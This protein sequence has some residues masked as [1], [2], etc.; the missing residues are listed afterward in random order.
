M[1]VLVTGAN[2]FLAANIVRELNRRGVPVRGLV[3]PSADLSA[4]EGADCELITGSYLNERDL[5]QAMETCDFVIHPAAFTG[6]TPTDLKYYLEPNVEGTRNVVRVCLQKGIKRLVYVSTVNTIGFG[7]ENHPGREDWPLNGRP[8]SHSGYAQS[9]VLAENLIREAIDNQG[10][11][12]VIVNPTFIIGP[13]DAKPSSNRMLLIYFERSFSLIPPGGKNFVYVG[14][15][16]VA[17]C[18]ALEMGKS[19]ERYI[20][21]HR[22]LTLNAFF[23]LVEKVVGRK[24][25]RI[26]IPGPLIRLAGQAGQLFDIFGPDYQLDPV[27]A[28]ILCIR[29]FYTAEKA[30]RELN[31]PQTPIERAI[32]E[33]WE[34]L[35]Q[36]KTKAG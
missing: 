7:T 18:N 35:Q 16:A 31:M 20:L 15:V 13:Y 29:N 22:N 34:W 6:P 8:F 4:L 9:K 36:H 12:A 32:Q 28:H 5:D 1:K 23:D 26:H 10:L 25:R 33:S 17:T 2:G 30:I 11:N 27:T 19:G 14:D 24:Q 21:A 3:R